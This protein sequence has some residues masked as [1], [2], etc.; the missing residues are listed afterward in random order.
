MLTSVVA[1]VGTTLWAD[2]LRRPHPLLLGVLVALLDL[3]PIV[4]STT[5]GVIASLVALTK[6]LPIALATVGLYAFYRL[7]ED[8]QLPPRVMRH[9]V[10]IFPSLTIIATLVGGVLLGPI[11]ALT[12]IPVAAAIRLILD[13]VTPPSLQRR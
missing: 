6:G 4:G 10:R 13:E 3:I 9:T 2:C 12:A 11:R 1:G 8:Y 7:I 5:G